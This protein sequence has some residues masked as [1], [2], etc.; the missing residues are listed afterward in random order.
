MAFYSITTD[1]RPLLAAGLTLDQ[2][3]AETGITIISTWVET[4]DGDW[5]VDEDGNRIASYQV[6][7]KGDLAR[8]DEWMRART[9]KAPAA[10]RADA[11]AT[12]RQIAYIRRLI[13]DGRGEEGG[14]MTVPADLTTLT[15][16][17]ASALINSL[18]GQY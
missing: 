13:L 15:K 11:P 14:F 10:A 8:W 6:Q 7:R 17:D 5:K 4:A 9:P 16:A 2:I 12:D 1:I 3:Q 18:T